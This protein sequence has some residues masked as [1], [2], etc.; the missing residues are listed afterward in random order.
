[1]GRKDGLEERPSARG[2]NEVL[3]QRWVAKEPLLR[4][5]EV[6]C[7][8]GPLLEAHGPM[9]KSLDLYLEICGE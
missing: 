9:L 3:R 4:R 7:I 1:M 2:M 8:L 5:E 6:R